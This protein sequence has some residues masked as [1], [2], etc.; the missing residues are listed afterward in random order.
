MQI[1]TITI[2][3]Y[4]NEKA[5][6]NKAEQ[7]KARGMEGKKGKEREENGRKCV[8][9]GSRGVGTGGPRGQG[10]QGPPPKFSEN[11]KSALFLVANGP[12]LL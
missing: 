11:A 6:Q 12:L 7:S 4:N 5:K 8:W 9:G 3:G 10:G 2:V 1:Y